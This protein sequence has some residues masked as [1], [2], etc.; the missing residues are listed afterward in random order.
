LI[1]DIVVTKLSE[2]YQLI[3]SDIEEIKRQIKRPEI[4]YQPIQSS[5]KG[6]NEG[7]GKTLLLQISPSI[8]R[9]DD[10]IMKNMDQKPKQLAVNP[11]S[12][13]SRESLSEV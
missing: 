6:E 13:L 5:Q 8:S 9:V 1:G 10:S 4:T 2:Y 3:S 7:T 12:N 11:N